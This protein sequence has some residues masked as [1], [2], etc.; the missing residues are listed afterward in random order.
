MQSL[1]SLFFTVLALGAAFL[2][3]DYFLAPAKDKMVFKKP[4]SN[5]QQ[6]EATQATPAT[7]Q[8]SHPAPQ[9]P[10]TTSAGTPLNPAPVAAPSAPAPMTPTVSA[11]AFMPP[12]I[13]SV[14]Q[15]TANWTRIP[16][17][18]FP[19][20]VKLIQPVAFKAAYGST[21]MATG[22]EVTALALQNGALILAPTP[23]SAAR[24]TVVI[25]ATDLK[26]TLTVA[27]NAWRERR[28]EEARIAWKGRDRSP[29]PSTSSPAVAA[30]GR[31]QPGVDGTYPLLLASM[32]A[33]VV[34]EV[35]PTSITR[36]GSAEPGDLNGRPCWMV[37]V[38]YDAQTAFGKFSTTAV[39][40]VVDGRVAGWFYKGSGEP[41][42]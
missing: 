36:W 24:A 12:P 40:K 1:K 33:G 27:Y 23:S 19:R 11:D 7:A 21:Q 32:R 29:A 42:P 25:D 28:T 6:S 16:A 2:A 18:A 3:Y 34:T 30:D 22:T 10:S 8:T 37:A 38:D 41:V 9:V 13:A 26:A 14:E 35:T 5:S 20:Q 39:A 31:P 15:A 4:P 17:T